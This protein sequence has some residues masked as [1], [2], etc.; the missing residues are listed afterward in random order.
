MNFSEVLKMAL[1][2][3][4]ANALR[5]VLTLLIIAVGIMSLVGILAALD[6]VLNSL[7]ESFNSLGSNSYTI[8][9]KFHPCATTSGSPP[10][11]VATT[12]FPMAI[13]S[14]T[15]IPNPS[16]SAGCTYRSRQA[17]NG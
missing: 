7:N 12:A 9:R 6:S 2:S 13:A 1:E 8:E 17:R 11:V 14:T 16:M 3:I 10:V 5:S 4:R 15:A